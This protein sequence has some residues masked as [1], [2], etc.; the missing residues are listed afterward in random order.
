MSA[1]GQYRGARLL[2]AGLAE[3]GSRVVAVCAGSRSTALALA[4]A[5][6]G[7]FDVRAFVDERAAAFFALGAA[8]VASAPAVVVT[9]SGTAVANLLP[10]V[11]EA[12]LAGV[13]LICV[14]ADRPPELH[15]AGAT[16]T[17]E[18][19]GLLSSADLRFAFD[20]PGYDEAVPHAHIAARAAA[21]ARGPKAGPVH[22]NVRFRE[23]LTPS[24]E[25]RAERF[26]GVRVS[27]QVATGVFEPSAAELDAAGGR[28]G[29]S[30]LG[31]IHVGHLEADSGLLGEAVSHLAA[32]SGYPVIVEATSRLR[33]VVDERV[34]IDAAEAVVRDEAF[35]REHQ[36]D[37]VV[38]IGRAPLT[39]AMG[40]FFET[41]GASQIVIGSD[42]PWPDPSAAATDVLRGDPAPVCMTLAGL[43]DGAGRDEK[44]LTAWHEAGAKA[45]AALDAFVDEDATPMFEGTVARTL[46]EALPSDALLTVA[47]SL[48]IRALDAYTSAADR[49]EVYANRGASGIDGTISA[50]FGAAAATGRPA[51]ALVGDLAFLHD[52]GGLLSAA[53]HRI[54]L[55]TVVVDN[56]GGGI[57]E[58]LPQASSLDR[59]TF[60]ELFIVP[61]ELDL[62]L[63]AEFAGCGFASAHDAGELEKSIAWAFT[64]GGPWV[65]RV[66]VKREQSVE[67]HRESLARAGQAI[68]GS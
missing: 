61:H 32:T 50:A 18:Q 57:F 45:R 39:R 28:V 41:S 30:P 60:D 29:T 55:V 16:Q 46:V 6:D 22:L 4:F 19:A 47:T 31:L 43:I 21:A 65:I 68:R 52:L 3:A 56:S 27:P 33:G 51:A 2:A 67:A 49:L 34:L 59:K 48:P 26:D 8:R 58:F 23:P 15:D 14:T 24:P 63:A 11:V 13:P 9:T 36:P 62:K 5:D 20:L 53:R 54:P 35:A 12:D 42:F 17:I 66:P 40:E 25:A 37:V 44:W 64:E 7:R 38:R 1:D 10:A